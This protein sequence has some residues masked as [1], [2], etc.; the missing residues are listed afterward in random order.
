[1][2]GGSVDRS[3]PV[4]AGWQTFAD[5]TSELTICSRCIQAQEESKCVRIE[6]RCRG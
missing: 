3:D 6:G 2:V 4:G 1:M 5:T